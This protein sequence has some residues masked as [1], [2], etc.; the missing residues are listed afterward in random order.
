MKALRKF[1]YGIYACFMAAGYLLLLFGIGFA[2]IAREFLRDRWYA[3][4]ARCR[5][6]PVTSRRASELLASRPSLEEAL[7]MPFCL[8]LES[9]R[10]PVAP[11]APP[12]D[13][14]VRF[15]VEIARQRR[16]TPAECNAPGRKVLPFPVGGRLRLG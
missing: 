9:S 14:I 16:S 1:G 11:P 10:R 6:K 2:I 3:L 7:D 5:R 8:G 12:P 4:L 15:P 13:N